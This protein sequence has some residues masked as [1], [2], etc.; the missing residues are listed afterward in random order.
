MDEFS[1]KLAL[2]TGA[3]RGLGR[4]IALAFSSCGASVAAHDINP[5][6]V[7]ELVNQIQRGGGIARE[8]VFDLAKRMPVEA[9]VSQV[10]EQLGRIDFLVNCASVAP[11]AHILD[12]DEWEFHRTLDMNLGGP[13]FC[14]QQAGRVMRQLGSGAIVNVVSSSEPGGMSK[15]FSAFLASQAGL[16]GLTKAA[17]AELSAFNIR[18]NSVCNFPPELEP[19]THLRMNLATLQKWRDI[20]PDLALGE[21]ADVVTLVLYLCSKDG[22]TLTGQVISVG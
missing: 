1:G 18:L 3:G 20:H 7:D 9:M 6:H 17:A 5:I 21:H 13:F 10:T 12:M 4:E 16:I 8:Y 19:A 15:G 11:N 14:I 22:A 2:I